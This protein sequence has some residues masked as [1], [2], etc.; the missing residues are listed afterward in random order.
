VKNELIEILQQIM[1][2]NLDFT[3]IYLAHL[4][5][6]TSRKIVSFDKALN[7]V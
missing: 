4:K 2:M 3:D 5:K 6:T 7:K 1:N